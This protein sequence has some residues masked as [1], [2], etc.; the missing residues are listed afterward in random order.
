MVSFSCE[1]SW[2][3]RVFSDLLAQHGLIFF[4]SLFSVLSIGLRRYFDQEEAR[5]SSEPMS[6]RVVYLR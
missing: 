6:G 1:V 4:S 5:S 3:N 2:N